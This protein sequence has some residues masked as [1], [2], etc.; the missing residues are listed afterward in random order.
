M[1]DFVVASEREG[2]RGVTEVFPTFIVKK[3]SDLMIRGHDFYAVWDADRGLWST[4]EDDA[5]RIIDN[6]LDVYAEQQRKRRPDQVFKVLHL[7]TAHNRMIKTLHTYLKDDMR[8]N[9]VPLDEK[10]TFADTKVTKRD[11]VSKRLPYSLESKETPA[12]DRIMETLYSPENRHKIEWCNGCVLSGDSTWVQKFLV[13][14][15]P[16]GTGKGTVLSISDMLFEGYTRSF[17]VKTLV[18]NSSFPLEAFKDGPLVAIQYDGDLSRIEDNAKLNSIVSHETMLV[19][20][21]F[22]SQ[23]QR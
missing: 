21:K 20:E 15:G 6:D 5:I 9:Y 1:L 13:L 19:N 10:L 3:S 17:E 23:Y 4:D 11:H 2:K 8:D 18:S 12:Y 16:G 7:R 14:Y 22:K